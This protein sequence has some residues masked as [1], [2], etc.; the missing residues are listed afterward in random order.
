MGRNVVKFMHRLFAIS[1]P[2]DNHPGNVFRFKGGD[3]VPVDYKI[4]NKWKPF[5]DFLNGKP[6]F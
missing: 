6:T 5:K 1:A 4:N 3:A 2:K